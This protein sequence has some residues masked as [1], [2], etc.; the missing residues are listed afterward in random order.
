MSKNL[1]GHSSSRFNINLL[2]IDA[3]SITATTGTFTNLNIGTYTATTLNVTGNFVSAGFARFTGTVQYDN[4]VINGTFQV[5]NSTSTGTA[6][7]NILSVTSVNITGSMTSPTA[8]IPTLT[9]NTDL[10][11]TNTTVASGNLNFIFH[12]FILLHQYSD[13]FLHPIYLTILQQVK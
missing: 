13:V 12:V 11:T 7:L 9:V 10:I 1:R 5:S 4:V 3:N 6:T 8:T 2:D